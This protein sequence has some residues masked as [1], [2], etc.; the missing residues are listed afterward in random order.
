M[1]ETEFRTWLSTDSHTLLRILLASARIIFE[2]CHEALRQTSRHRARKRQA[3]T[4][5]MPGL[6]KRLHRRVLDVHIRWTH[7]APCK[8]RVFLQRPRDHSPLHATSHPRPCRQP[9]RASRTAGQQLT[10]P[11]LETLRRV[12]SCLCG[13]LRRPQLS[14]LFLCKTFRNAFL[15]LAGFGVCTAPGVVVVVNERE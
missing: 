3:W 12:S 15:R 7:R 10:S 13:C 6:R 4:A 9:P 5:R 8:V 14:T 1:S 2:V 11:L